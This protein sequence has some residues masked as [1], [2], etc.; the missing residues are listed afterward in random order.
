MFIFQR[1]YD[2]L[3]AFLTILALVPVCTFGQTSLL[4]GDMAI[5][6]IQSDAPDAF[7]WMSFVDLEA[8]TVIKFSENAIQSDGR[9]KSNE[10]TITFTASSAI[11]KGVVQ[12][13]Y[14][15]TTD[16]QYS[17][18]GSVAFSASGDQVIAYQE[19]G[20][21][22]TFLYYAGFAK[23][24][25]VITS[26]DP[27]TN[28]SYVPS[29][30]ST[31][32]YTV[33]DM[34][35]TDNYYYKTSNGASGTASELLASIGAT[36]NW[37]A[38]SDAISSGATVQVSDFSVTVASSNTSI[39]FTSSSDSAVESTGTYD[40][41]VSITNEDASNATTVDVAL[42][43]GSATNGTDFSTYSNETLTF[44][45]GNSTSQTV[46]LTIMDDTVVE[47]KETVIF[48]LQNVSGGNSA[49][50]GSTSQF[51]LTIRDNELIIN[52][53]HADPDATN[54][55]S[56][57]DGTVSSTQDEFVE[58]VNNSGGA[59]D[60][61][62]W[63]ISDAV[64]VK[65]TFESGTTLMKGQGIV[66]FAGGTP[67]GTFGG[68]ITNTAGSLN[69]NNSGDSIT[70]TNSDGTVV[71]TDTYGSEAGDNQSITRD[72][73][74]TGSFMKHSAATGADGSLFSPGTKVDGTTFA[75]AS[76]TVTELDGGTK[77]TEG[78]TT[79]SYTLVLGSS[80]SADVTITVSP[81]AQTVVSPGTVIFTSSDFSTAQTV[82]VTAVNDA[83]VEGNHTSTISHSV[84]SSD[85]NYNGISIS[86]VTVVVTDNDNPGVT[87]TEAGGS[88]A[89]TEGDT[90]DYYTVVL[91]SQPIDTVIISVTASD[92]N[93]VVDQSKLAFT[94]GNY[95]TAQTVNVSA[96]DDGKDEENHT[97]TITHSVSSDDTNYS[98][99]TINS[100]IVTV[101][102]DDTAGITVIET[103]GSTAV[104]EG[105]TSDY[106]TVV[107]QSQPTATVTIVLAAS[108]TDISVD[109]DTLIFSATN[110]DDTQEVIVTAT[111]DSDPEKPE[112]A[113][114]SHTVTSSDSIYDGFSVDNISITISDNDVYP[115][116][117]NEIH[118][119]PST[120]QGS[121]RDFEFLELFNMGS[122][123]A[124][125]TGYTFS[126]GVTHTF[127]DSDTIASQSVLVVT[128]NAESYVESVQWQSGGLKNDGE[129]VVL[130]S[131]G[132]FTVDSVTYG[133][134]EPWPRSPNG[135]GPSLQLIH[136][137]MANELVFNWA[138]SIEMG[139]S[140]GAVQLG[141][142]P[143]VAVADSYTALEDST[144]AVLAPGVLSNDSDWEGKTLRA[145]LVDSS[146]HGTVVLDSTGAFIYSPKMNFFGADTFRYVA[147]DTADSSVA[148]AVA[149]KVVSVNDPPTPFAAVSPSDSLYVGISEE[150][151][152]HEILFAWTSSTDVDNS[153]IYRLVGLDSVAFLTRDSLT[154]PAVIMTYREI[155]PSLDSI[156]IVRGQWTVEACDN[157]T[158]VMASNGPFEII[159]DQRRLSTKANLAVPTSFVL[160]PNFPNPFNPVT[161]I[162]YDLPIRAK[163]DLTIFDLMGRKVITFVNRT[164]DAGFRSVQWDGTDD[165][166]R[167]VSAG[168]Y[169]YQIQAGEFSQ[170]RKMLLLK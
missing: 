118:Y 38:S 48:Q 58:L 163:V 168:V 65:H 125:L 64:G 95:S 100:V 164:E 49:E 143:P 110:Y 9:L 82:T 89:V 97:S 76:V 158:A 165:L 45:A 126:K 8:N 26:E 22:K 46:T 16:D 12:R 33:I 2:R 87:V 5:V 39:Q 129:A 166:G 151:L 84:A 73:D 135:D 53:I 114:I 116:V 51:T 157:D 47:G 138:A 112:T 21:N 161:T 153:V 98:H 55:D 119:N 14:S 32:A 147:V 23:A 88:T 154:V 71:A 120:V 141:N 159:F 148:T 1:V 109:P 123:T 41:T 96:V 15:G 20:E 35:S 78:D 137:L 140:P 61:S 113:T 122:V 43:D 27:S 37:T 133:P 102:D 160:Y 170:T 81:D 4:A 111:D 10:G 92:T 7:E 83:T 132:G 68:S 63:T 128:G 36:S 152:H 149:L 28:T 79:D 34:G 77:V 50:I 155:V 70:V 101:V 86:S 75:E 80:P 42:T 142:A 127:S 94:S 72:P 167:S 156:G 106:Y 57:G 104:T 11:S 93:I 144:L 74:L 90:S 131:E 66:V 69:L 18:S 56:N 130:I 99:I 150:T 105:D 25:T 117:I 19:S 6:L 44:S 30:L 17:T 169:L 107:L 24:T 29:G 62:D 124:Y 91:Q 146:A 136:P 31:G 3:T 85:A 60:I 52:E 59:M 115:L 40:L 134:I 162:R 145:V 121:D 54:G 108:T 103:D 13:W 139:G 67:T